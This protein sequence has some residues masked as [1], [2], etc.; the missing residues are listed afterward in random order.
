MLKNGIQVSDA[1]SHVRL[2]ATSSNIFQ[3]VSD[4]FVNSIYVAI[5]TRKL[6]WLKKI[7]FQS[8]SARVRRFIFDVRSIFRGQFRGLLP[9]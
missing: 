5:C 8:G 2:K 9:N 7:K 4:N 1:T 3:F 6:T